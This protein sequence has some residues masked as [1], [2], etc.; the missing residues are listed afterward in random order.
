MENRKEKYW[1]VTRFIFG[2]PLVFTY[3]LFLTIS[4]HSFGGRAAL[5]H[6]ISFLFFGAIARE[7]KVRFTDK[8]IIDEGLAQYLL[9]LSDRYI[10]KQDAE[11][12]VS[13][14]L[15][16]SFIYVV[17]AQDGSRRSRL[18]LRTKKLREQFGSEYV[19]MWNKVLEKNYT[20]IAEEIMSSQKRAIIDN[21]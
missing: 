3:F 12:M 4:R 14:L 10:T 1:Y 20:Y 9:S 7:Q 15:K 17:H 2:H 11:R 5:W 13:F 8:Y 21:T 18:D 19:K 6:K 16:D